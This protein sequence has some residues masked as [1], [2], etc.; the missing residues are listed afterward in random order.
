[1]SQ[2]EDGSWAKTTRVLRYNPDGS[3]TD[4]NGIR[5]ALVANRDWLEENAS[6]KGGRLYEEVKRQT[7]QLGAIDVFRK[8]HAAHV[9]IID[10]WVQPIGD[11][12]KAHGGAGGRAN[13]MVRRFDNILL[14]HA[15]GIHALS[16]VWS[17]A[18]RGVEDASGSRTTGY[19]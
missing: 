17:K 1:M 13:E 5:S 8:Y 9:G 7:N 12:L 2:R 15:Q 16:A 18:L 14:Q 3:P 19:F 10:R 11:E 4:P 6:R